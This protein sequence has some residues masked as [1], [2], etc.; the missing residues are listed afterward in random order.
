MV[1]A[2]EAESHG[3][4][5]EGLQVPEGRSA[6]FQCAQK[7]VHRPAT[8]QTSGWPSL[9]MQGK[10]ATHSLFLSPYSVLIFFKK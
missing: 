2:M 7:T 8:S 6:F 10:I 1:I 4:S 5:Q 3:G 9:T